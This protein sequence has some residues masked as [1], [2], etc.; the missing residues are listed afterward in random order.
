MGE[1]VVDLAPHS[2][3]LLPQ[4]GSHV[5]LAG[6]GGALGLEREERVRCLEAV[7]EVA[8]LGD[9]TLYGLFALLEKPVQIID[10]QLDLGDVSAA[11]SR[12]GAAVHGRKALTQLGKVSI[13]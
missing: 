10:E 11:E 2:G 4:R 13:K 1:V 6:G 9:R 7:R 3:N 5:F 8:G 12:L